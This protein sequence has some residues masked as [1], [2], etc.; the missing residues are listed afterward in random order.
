MP[1]PALDL[2]SDHSLSAFPLPFCRAWPSRD[3]VTAAAM[4]HGPFCTA[5]QEDLEGARPDP[6]RK[7]LHLNTGIIGGARTPKSY[8]RHLSTA[9]IL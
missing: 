1:P 2:G 9:A 4:P 6:P 8:W 7:G 5:Y 3:Y